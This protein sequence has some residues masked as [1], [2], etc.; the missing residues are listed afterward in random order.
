MTMDADVIVIGAGLAGLSA[1]RR[2]SDADRSVV[3]LEARDRVGGRVEAGALDDGQWIEFGAQWIGPGQA[4]M[5]EL[6][7]ELGLT[8]VPTHNDGDLLFS[9]AGRSGRLE[10]RKG[11]IP[12]LS[13]FALA[14]LAQGMSRFHRLARSVNLIAPWRTPKAVFLDGQTF[15]T[16]VRRNL[17]TKAGRAY[18]ELYCEAVFAAQPRDMSLLHAAF[19]TSS[20]KDMDTLMATD[21]GAQKDRVDGGSWRVCERLATGLDVRLSDSVVSVTQDDSGVVVTTTSG[22]VFRGRHVIVTLPP[23]LAGR[24]SYQPPMPA[25]RDQLTQKVPAGSVIK[26]FAVYPEPFWRAEGLNGQVATDRGPVK[27]VFD[28]TPPGYSRGVLLGF[29]EGDEAR[30]WSGRPAE[31]RRRAV[32]GSFVRHFGDRAAEPGEYHERDWTSEPYSRGCYGAHFGPGVW[33]RFGPALKPPVG[34]IHWAGTEY[35][36]IWNGYMEGAVRS[37]ESTAA[38]VLAERAVN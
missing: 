38:A 28:S 37:G 23:T 22:A 15:E 30:I 17:R 14:D 2:L 10:G 31:E 12:K 25:L 27:V 19:Y 34:R 7:R 24:L 4:R 32:I 9:L 13:P 36:A 20:G 26:C 6:V 35:S 18:F 21:E 8:T 1:A 33:S 11:A 29:L 5:Y 3:V 16:W